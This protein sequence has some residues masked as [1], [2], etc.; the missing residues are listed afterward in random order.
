MKNLTKILILSLAV[1][2]VTGCSKKFYE[3]DEFKVLKRKHQKVAVLPAQIAM[4]GKVKQ[5]AKTSLKNVSVEK[6][7]EYQQA[8]INDLQREQDSY[9]VTVLDKEITNQKLEEDY[10]KFYDLQRTEVKKLGNA[11]RVDGIFYTEI[12]SAIVLGKDPGSDSKDK[13]HVKVTLKEANNERVMWTYE[14]D[15]KAKN[16]YTIEAIEDKIFDKIKGKFPYK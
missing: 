13:V 4:D 12:E 16:T 6:A 7:Y 3:A 9:S 5:S 1:L 10:I 8:L 11:L 2:A 15:Y 14:D